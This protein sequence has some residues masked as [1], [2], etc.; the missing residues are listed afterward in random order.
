MMLY[1]YDFGNPP[2]YCAK[3]V[4]G[5]M[6]D[7]TPSIKVRPMLPADWPGVAEIY[8]QGIETNLATLQPECPTWEEWDRAHIEDC[9]FVAEKDGDIIGWVALTPVSDRCVYSGVAE[10]SIYIHPNHQGKGVAQ[11]LMEELIGASERAGYWTLQSSILSENEPSIALHKAAG[12]RT[13]GF[14]ERIGRDKAGAWRS[15]VL[16]ERR[17]QNIAT[18]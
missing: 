1:L 18:D 5:K 14:R 7:K 6:S 9:R 8:Q 10:V 11:T 17:S 12:Y 4:L 2:S 15:I 13:V 16:M 3:E